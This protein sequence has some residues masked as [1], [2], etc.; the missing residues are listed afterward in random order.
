V[1]GRATAVKVA[2]REAS[3]ARVEVLVISA[4]VVEVAMD[5]AVEATVVALTETTVAAVATGAVR[6]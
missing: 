6:V 4:V 1:V 5:V 3:A 2:M